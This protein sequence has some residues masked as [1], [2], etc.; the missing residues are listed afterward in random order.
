MRT[1]FA[2]VDMEAPLSNERGAIGYNGFKR[3]LGLGV[4]PLTNIVS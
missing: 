4:W 2:T 1:N 3:S